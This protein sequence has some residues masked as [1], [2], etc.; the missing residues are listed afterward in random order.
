MV[1]MLDYEC[2]QKEWSKMIRSSVNDWDTNVEIIVQWSPFSSEADL[3]RQ[4]NLMKDYGVN[5][6]EENIQMAKKFPNSR[7]FLT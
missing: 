3:F 4:F 6:D 5:R 2:Q 1:P 7:H